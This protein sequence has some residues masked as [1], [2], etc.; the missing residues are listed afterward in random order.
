M[1]PTLPKVY[2]L[3]E[4]LSKF[5][6]KNVSMF[7]C[8]WTIQLSVD[9]SNNC[10]STSG[11]HSIISYNSISWLNNN[12]L[13]WM[14]DFIDRLYFNRNQMLYYSSK[15]YKQLS[16]LVVLKTATRT[17]PSIPGISSSTF[18]SFQYHLVVESLFSN[19][20]SPIDISR[21]SFPLLLTLDCS[22]KLVRYSLLHFLV[23]C[24]SKL[25]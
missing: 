24:W 18:A 7:D 14:C 1:F 17:L 21:A 10:C 6:E 22:R 11:T 25:L 23:D 13:C 8:S 15:I 12:G 16:L 4:K 20:T 2:S 3:R 9:F 5:I 19:T